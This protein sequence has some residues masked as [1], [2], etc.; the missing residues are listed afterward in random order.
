LEIGLYS[1]C[2]SENSLEE[3]ALAEAV[4]TEVDGVSAWVMKAEHLVAIALHTGR[5]KDHARILQ[6]LET[7]RVDEE[8]LTTVMTRHGLLPQWQRFRKKYLEE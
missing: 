4:Q 5:P 1:S 6:F 8:A 3:E 7:G 2:P